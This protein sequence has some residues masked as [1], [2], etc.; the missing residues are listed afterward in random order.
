[1]TEVCRLGA[2]HTARSAKHF[3][4]FVRIF[5]QAKKKV[6]YSTPP[7]FSAH[8]H[9]RCINLQ[10]HS[11]NLQ[12]LVLKIPSNYFKFAAA[13]FD[14]QQLYQLFNLQLFACGPP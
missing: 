4:K 7:S 13:L 10:Q 9:F 12:Q 1:M 8:A 14:L 6:Y 2:F 5:T 11:F 3:R